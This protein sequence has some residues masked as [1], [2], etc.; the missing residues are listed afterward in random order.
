MDLIGGVGTIALGLV[1]VGSAVIARYRSG[2]P[3][4][5]NALIW[6]TLIAIG[7]AVALTMDRQHS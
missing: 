2:Q 1:L 6:A 3:I 5:R 7:F 4:A